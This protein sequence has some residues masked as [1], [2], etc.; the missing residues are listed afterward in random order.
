MLNPNDSKLV[1]LVVRF[2]FNENFQQIRRR[3]NYGTNPNECRSDAVTVKRLTNGCWT[4]ES[5]APDPGANLDGDEACMFKGTGRGT[6]AS[7][8]SQGT[9]HMPFLMTLQEITGFENNGDPILDSC[10]PPQ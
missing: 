10:I 3:I 4:V 2:G 7:I 6:N 9:Y 5:I 8:E 1:N